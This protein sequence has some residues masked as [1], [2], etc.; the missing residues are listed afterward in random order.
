MYKKQFIRGGNVLTLESPGPQLIINTFNVPTKP[1]KEDWPIL[2]EYIPERISHVFV[3][4]EYD[5]IANRGTVTIPGLLPTQLLVGDAM[6]TFIQDVNLN[7]KISEFLT[8][9]ER[10]GV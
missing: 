5:F 6:L 7:W 10:Q 4:M 8:Y 9:S 1:L 3:Q 2:R